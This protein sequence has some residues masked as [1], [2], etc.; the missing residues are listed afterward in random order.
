[1]SDYILLEGIRLRAQLR[2]GMTAD[3]D[4]TIKI[5]SDL[6]DRAGWIATAERLPA[7]RVAVTVIYKIRDEIHATDLGEFQGDGKTWAGEHGFMPASNVV[8][9][10]EIPMPP[11]G[12]KL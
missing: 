10:H 1:M 11:N 7:D 9:W 6:I 3:R 2:M 4:A 12:I 8:Y 5:I